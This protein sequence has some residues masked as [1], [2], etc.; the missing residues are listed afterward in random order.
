MKT[1][2]TKSDAMVHEVEVDPPASIPELL[3]E[4]ATPSADTTT[5]R[6]ALASGRVVEAD[7]EGPGRDRLTIRSST[8]EV[9][10]QIC[11]TEKGPLLRFKAA[12]VELEATR[13]VK[14]KCEEFHVHAEK[15]I[16]QESGGD[17]RQRIGGQAD[18][19]VRGRMT[20]AARETR[21]QAKRGNV[22][23]E[24]ND[25]VEVLGERIKLNC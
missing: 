1:I 4:I 3:A 17:L 6:M 24:A 14:V 11:M 20:L 12:D 16:V 7:V 15:Q 8:G 2:D 19:K 13:D 22:Q 9:E 25:D 21:L 23:I 18:V 5:Q 10:L